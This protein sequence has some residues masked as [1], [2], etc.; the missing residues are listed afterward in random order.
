M[1]LLSKHSNRTRPGFTMVELLIVVVIIGILI[2]LL[3]PVIG[4]IREKA[5]KT[6]SR[7]LI[8]G[9]SAALERYHIDFDEYPPSTLPDLGDPGSPQIDSLFRY[10]C[11][12]E[13]KGITKTTG[14]KKRL[15]EPYINVPPEFIKRVEDRY[16]IVDSWGTDIVFLNS[17]AYVD[18]FAGGNINK[19]LKEDKVMNPT[20]F[21]IFSKGPDRM[22]DPDPRNLVDDVT[23]W[24]QIKKVQ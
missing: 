10:L 6:A 17:K 24:S 19:I 22:R 5:R 14:S 16:V 21:D 12:P 9:L 2:S 1:A 20:A 23:N 7:A 18:M 4:N 3:L 13:G 11:G 15:I 8:D